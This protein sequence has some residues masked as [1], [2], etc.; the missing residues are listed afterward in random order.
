MLSNQRVVR[1]LHTDS[2]RDHVSITFPT[3]RGA[4]CEVACTY[5]PVS[6]EVRLGGVWHPQDPYAEVEDLPPLKSVEAPPQSRRVASML[7]M[8]CLPAVVFPFWVDVVVSTLALCT[9]LCAWGAVVALATGG[10]TALFALSLVLFFAGV[11]V[12]CRQALTIAPL[13][14]CGRRAGRLLL[15][16]LRAC[17]PF[18]GPAMW[19]TITRARAGVSGVVD[20]ALPPIG[21]DRARALACTQAVAMAWPTAA[22]GLGALVSGATGGLPLLAVWAGVAVS[23][24]LM[25]TV[26]A[27]RVDE[28]AQVYS[29]LSRSVRTGHHGSRPAAIGG[30]CRL[31]FL[32]NLYVGIAI[33]APLPQRFDVLMLSQAWRLRCY[34]SCWSG[35]ASWPPRAVLVVSSGVFAACWWRLVSTERAWMEFPSRAVVG[36]GVVLHGVSAQLTCDMERIPCPGN[37]CANILDWPCM[38]GRR[39]G[40]FV[41]AMG[42]FSTLRHRNTFYR[43]VC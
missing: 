5:P 4:L 15:L 16:L 25:I 37:Q 23:A 8:R 35:S 18:G 10:H 41:G 43:C 42:Q 1:Y 28:S 9:C 14:L 22:L 30:P 26:A 2:I 24:G 39:S 17:L 36:P 19:H 20:A 7:L 6:A 38:C 29:A 13:T 12:Q 27:I 31:L 33:T 11:M 40:W 34:V 32:G 3:S 21:V